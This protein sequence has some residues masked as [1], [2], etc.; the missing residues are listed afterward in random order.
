ME[1][2]YNPI[3]MDFL[4]ANVTGGYNDSKGLSGSGQVVTGI[5]GMD[6]SRFGACL[7]GAGPPDSLRSDDGTGGAGEGGCSIGGT[8]PPIV[9][10]GLLGALCDV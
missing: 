9:I 8:V 10:P 5:A 6:S 7:I 4:G 1:I 3:L 2:D